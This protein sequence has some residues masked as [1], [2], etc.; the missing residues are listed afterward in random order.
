MAQRNVDTV[1]KANIKNS[2]PEI[3]NLKYRIVFLVPGTAVIR[4]STSAV[5]GLVLSHNASLSPCMR[6]ECVVK[7]I[8]LGLACVISHQSYTWRILTFSPDDDLV[9]I[10]PMWAFLHAIS[11]LFPSQ[12]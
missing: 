1:G 9:C 8:S 4:C 11:E 6:T 3:L 12:F 5:C 2:E 10:P 7:S